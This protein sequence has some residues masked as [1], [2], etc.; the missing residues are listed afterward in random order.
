MDINPND[1]KPFAVG[2]IGAVIAAFKWLPGV[3]WFERVLNAVA[4][5]AIAGFGAPVLVEY[6]RLDHSEAYRNGAAFV[7][8]LL[9]LSL[10]AAVFEAMK[11][12]SL[13]KLI[14]AKL[15][16]WAARFG[17]KED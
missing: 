17:L 2:G 8:G 13:S 14:A 7:I 11:E 12:L 3:N 6:L 4:G 10:V 15:R 16:A 9:G 5:T 1:V